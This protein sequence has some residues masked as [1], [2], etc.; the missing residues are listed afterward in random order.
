MHYG[1]EPHKKPHRLGLLGSMSLPATTYLL[2]LAM[3]KAI[4]LASSV[5][6]TQQIP[7]SFF[8]LFCTWINKITEKKKQL[9]F[10]FHS[11]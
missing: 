2:P 5:M 4:L 9:F 10:Y 11:S 7:G 3:P 8:S 1:N 6:A